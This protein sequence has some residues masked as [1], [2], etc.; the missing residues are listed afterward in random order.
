MTRETRIDDGLYILCFSRN[1]VKVQADGYLKVL[2]RRTLDHAVL[3][4]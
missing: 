2:I 1:A 3:R 4:A